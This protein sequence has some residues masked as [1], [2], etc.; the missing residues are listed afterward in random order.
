MEKL[1]RVLFMA[2]CIILSLTACSNEKEQVE[3]SKSAEE[4][5]TKEVEVKEETNELVKIKVS[6]PVRGLLWG[7]IHITKE[8]GFFEEQGL[9]VEF[10]LVQGDAPTAPVLSGDAQFGLFGPEMIV[11]LNA[12]GQG[13][14]LLLTCTD[15]FPYTFVFAPGISSYDELKGTSVA[16]ADSGSSPRQFVRTVLEKNGLNPDG[17]VS[18]VNLPIA[19]LVSGLGS[20]E[21][22]ASYVSPESRNLAVEQGATIQIDMYDPEVHKEILGS[23]TY[24]MYITFATDE[25]IKENPEIVQKYVNA[26]YKGILWTQSH[27]TEEIVEALRPQHSSN[28]NL[29]SIIKEIMDNDIYTKD[30]S[31]TEEGYKA[32]NNM[33]ISAGVADKEIPFNEV[34]DDSFLN[35]AKENINLD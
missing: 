3:E 1:K 21:I 35:N 25:Y 26:I 4:I 34:I 28:E 13:A 20:G 8:L 30:G 23:E 5:E 15:K 24:G 31:F 19:S 22:S 27:T 2:L 29:D 32:I 16:A 9:D 12:K 17:D 6:E 14:K 11:G 7:P 33:A 18:Y 10:V